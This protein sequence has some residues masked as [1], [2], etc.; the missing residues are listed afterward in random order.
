MASH[1]S[2]FTV[3]R[4]ADTDDKYGPNKLTLWI[5]F[6]TDDAQTI[7]T[8]MHV[9]PKNISDIPSNKRFGGDSVGDWWEIVKR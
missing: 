2:N 6:T 9:I 3:G 8:Y 5:T 7:T 4:T 1:V